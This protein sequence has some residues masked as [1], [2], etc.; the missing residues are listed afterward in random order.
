MAKNKYKD[1]YPW[2]VLDQYRGTDFQGEWPTI[3]ELFDLS[4][5]RFPHNKCFTSI[6]P[7]KEEY[8]YTQVH[9]LVT[10]IGNYLVKLGVKK[11]DKVAVS[12]KNS[13]Q[14]AIAYL[15]IAYSG[16]IIVPLDYALHDDEMEKLMAFAGVSYLFIDKERINDI[17]KDGKVGLKGKFS[18]EKGDPDHPYVFD[19]IEKENLP[20]EKAVETDTAA[21]LFTSGT[22]GTPKGVMLSHRNLISDTFI[23]T[24]YMPLYES[25]VF[26]AIL[27]IHHAYTMVAVFFETW[28]VGA[29]CV[30]G[31]RLIVSIMLKE[32]HE[33]KVT[34]FL[35]VPML[36]NKMIGALLSGIRKKGIVVYGVVRFLMGF[37][38]LVKKMFGVNIGK[39]MF[40]G[41]LAKL[42]LDTNRICICGAGPLP[43]STFRHFN[44][45]GIDF[46]QGYGLTEAS[47]IT[48][49]NP[50]WHYKETSV[51]T[52]FLQEEVKIVDPDSDGN[53]LIY[54]KGPNIMQGYYHN[55]EATKE[56]LSDDGWLN[57]G[58]VGHQDDESYLFL[59]GRAKNIIVT[60]GGK[61][62]FPE[63]IEDHFQLYDDI[64]TICV[65]SY[66][67]DKET[68]SEGIR[69]IIYPSAAY[70]KATKEANPDSWEKVIQKHMEDI[71]EEVNR[72]LQSYKKITRVLVTYEPLPLTST[73]KVKRF[74][75]HKMYGD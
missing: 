30:F 38:G 13:P 27:P 18:L 7:E 59:T 3:P 35:G 28:S 24:Y 42:S 68:K 25:D 71:V 15:G 64:D 51:G 70:T 72:D 45:L 17:D 1:V 16:A 12:G 52:K 40:K 50:P 19:C 61:N 33:G 36:F 22:T 23:C 47:P 55:E 29:S 66:L 69:A 48:H 46:V 14:W 56:V 74:L 6:I 21:I 31:K 5:K 44:Q 62:V 32:L 20:R 41:L 39:K 53:G 57:T 58:D 10:A 8:D 60:E 73:K 37:S 26:Y 75:V 65:T 49:L 9:E 2:K 34:M 43:A 4:T 54:I 67:I 63:E 11:G